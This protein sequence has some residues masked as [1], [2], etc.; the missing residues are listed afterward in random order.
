M[1]FSQLVAIINTSEWVIEN[2]TSS[3]FWPNQTVTMK[4]TT[5][6]MNEKM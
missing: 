2:Q 3:R 5:V 4:F 1:P 6:R